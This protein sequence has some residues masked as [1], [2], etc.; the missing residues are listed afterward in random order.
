MKGP[1]MPST[2]A[3]E[4]I[5]ACFDQG[6]RHVVLHG[7][8]GSGRT[9]HG[10]A[11]LEGKLAGTKPTYCVGWLDAEASKSAEE[12]VSALENFI[13]HSRSGSE[14]GPS[15]ALAVD[16]LPHGDCERIIDACRR[17]PGVELLIVSDAA[18][19]SGTASLTLSPWTTDELILLMNGDPR[20]F[21]L[22]AFPCP[23]EDL[24][25]L[26]S[27]GGLIPATVDALYRALAISDLEGLLSIPR[28]SNVERSKHPLMELLT[29]SRSWQERW[30]QA[31][32][33][34]RRGWASLASFAG[35]FE[36]GP[37]LEI[38]DALDLHPDYLSSIDAIEGLIR[39]NIIDKFPSANGSMLIL[40]PGARLLARKVLR[41]DKELAAQVLPARVAHGKS[42]IHEGRG[43]AD[44]LE[45]GYLDGAARRR[46]HLWRDEIEQTLMSLEEDSA[47][48]DVCG[49]RH[50][51]LSLATATSFISFEE[52]QHHRALEILRERIPGDEELAK[53]DRD[54]QRT[55][56]AALRAQS[57]I[58][59]S[60]GLL[61]GARRAVHRACALANALGEPQAMARTAYEEAVVARALGDA[62]GARE[63]IE[64]GLAIAEKG[65]LLEEVARQTCLKA[66]VLHTFDGHR[67]A[68]PFHRQ[69]L[70]FA[71]QAQLPALEAHI[72]TH[73]G[74]VYW[75]EGDLVRARTALKTAEMR[76]VD[77]ED[78][79]ARASTLTGLG[80]VA[81]ELG[82]T[83]EA[84]RYASE[85]SRLHRTVGQTLPDGMT[86]VLRSRICL[87]EGDAPR[88][89]HF[90]VEALT[91]IPR[92]ASS[93]WQQKLDIA[94][95]QIALMRGDCDRADAVAERSLAQENLLGAARIEMVFV[96]LLTALKRNDALRASALTT[97]L[98][99]LDPLS[100]VHGAAIQGLQ[101]IVELVMASNL[102]QQPLLEDAARAFVG[103]FE[104]QPGRAHLRISSRLRFWLSLLDGLVHPAHRNELWARALNANHDTWV[105]AGYEVRPPDA[106]SIGKP[107]KKPEG[108]I[109]LHRRLVPA[110]LFA[111]LVDAHQ[112]PEE[113]TLSDDALIAIGW[114]GESILADSAISR[115][116]KTVSDLRKLGPGVLIERTGLGYAIQ[117]D[118]RIAFVPKTFNDWWEKER[119][120]A[121]EE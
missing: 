87:D 57:K 92:T 91:A 121:F 86:L 112:A 116:Q 27:L 113:N 64:R 62:E 4:A 78:E 103:L 71:R 20:A 10:R 22:R 84:H 119:P 99:A 69:A 46:L 98:G 31:P 1:Q 77:I 109:D 59:A 38:I 58:M 76:Q 75:R 28:L 49:D 90:L 41:Q 3:L 53:A 13:A 81:L 72:L 51:I 63:A 68:E 111:A 11:W 120:Q 66:I 67:A 2:R 35:P 100:D 9:L 52:R 16:N 45:F 37:A 107:N 39:Y 83:A 26:L 105:I 47:L 70:A 14:G 5:K 54:L 102:D 96:H 18:P 43:I 115:L 79:R 42:C 85:A 30:D 56:C 61:E 108:W 93:T 34:T 8:P 25:R 104:I 32:V 55:T 60:S 65:L 117:A 7:P 74:N 88:A 40:W 48:G 114:P 29:N 21:A 17:H 50:A 23:D 36:L 101:P 82:A 6:A 24:A 33:A 106:L 97:K 118:A 73:L 12:V 80:T 94:E 15:I 19:S 95:A 110:R 44:A 89:E